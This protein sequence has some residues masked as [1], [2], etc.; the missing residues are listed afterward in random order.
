MAWSYKT[1]KTF[2]IDYIVDHETGDTLNNIDAY[3]WLLKPGAEENTWNQVLEAYQRVTWKE[4]IEKRNQL[5]TESDWI[6]VKHQEIGQPIP[7]AWKT[8][9]QQ[10]RDLPYSVPDVD[11]LTWPTKPE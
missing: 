10:L 3:E 9:R 2:M 8:Y 1:G 4:V 7:T 5:L 6:V 11:L